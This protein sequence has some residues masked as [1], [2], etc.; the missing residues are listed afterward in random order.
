MQILSYWL[1]KVKYLWETR[2]WNIPFNN[3][4]LGVGIFIRLFETKQYD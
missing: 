3:W 2:P 4:P 1:V